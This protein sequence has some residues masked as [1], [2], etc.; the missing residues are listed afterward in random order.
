MSVVVPFKAGGLYQDVRP[1]DLEP[2]CAAG[3]GHP[4]TIERDADLVSV[5]SGPG[6]SVQDR[7]CHQPVGLCGNRLDSGHKTIGASTF[8]DLRNVG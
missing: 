1:I 2:R 4:P 6:I 8:P 7:R 5:D 3:L